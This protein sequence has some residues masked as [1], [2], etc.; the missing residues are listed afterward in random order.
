MKEHLIIDGRSKNKLK[1]QKVGIYAANESF[2]KSLKDRDFLFSWDD[3]PVTLLI[4]LDEL[5]FHYSPVPKDIDSLRV[6]ARESCLIEYSNLKEQ[7]NKPLPVSTFNDEQIFDSFVYAATHEL[8]ID[9]KKNNFSSFLKNFSAFDGMSLPEV[10][11]QS[12]PVEDLKKEAALKLKKLFDK[13][14]VS[15]ELQEKIRNTVHNFWENFNIL[16]NLK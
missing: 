2:K 7:Y 1:A 13:K 15:T 6:I 11:A 4:N 10:V 5:H 3:D 16:P 12:Y 14:S 9:R 8:L